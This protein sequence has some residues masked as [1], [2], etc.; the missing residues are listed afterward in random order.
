MPSNKSKSDEISQSRPYEKITGPRHIL[1]AAS[2]SYGGVKRLL[3]EAAFR[4]E[5]ILFGVVVL[6][7][8]Y[9]GAELPQYLVATC[10]FFILIA[11]EAI[12]TTIEILVDKIS[13]ELS[14]F[15]KQT[16]D[17]GSFAVFCLLCANGLYAAYIIWQAIAFQP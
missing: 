10:L 3:R 14:T 8:A 15:A 13:P 4:Q 11:V 12:N 6:L 16:K 9:I 17:L 2:Y 7:F 5:I 1:A